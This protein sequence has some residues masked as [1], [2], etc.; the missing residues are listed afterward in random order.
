MATKPRSERE[1]VMTVRL[2]RELHEQLKAA[3]EAGE[4]GIAAELRRRLEA[5]FVEPTTTSVDLET[6]RLLNAVAWISTAVKDAYG[7]SW[8]TDPDAGDV[9]RRAVCGDLMGWATAAGEAAPRAPKPGSA[10]AHLLEKG[11]ITDP[12]VAI[13]FAAAAKEGFI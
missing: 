2:P 9:L 12:A 8:R 10:I 7:A 11:P 6:R 3:A 13:G 1:T 4:G 5:S